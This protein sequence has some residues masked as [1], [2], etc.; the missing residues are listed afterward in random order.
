MC[1]LLYNSPLLAVTR[2]EITDVCLS[3]YISVGEAQTSNLYGHS[4]AYLNA[5]V[6]VSNSIIVRVCVLIAFTAELAMYS[7]IK[8]KL[9]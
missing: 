9:K 2:N 1:V 3:N 6:T 7:A 4:V 8:H 5:T